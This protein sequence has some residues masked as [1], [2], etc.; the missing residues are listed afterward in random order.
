M[1][2]IKEYKGILIIVLVVIL[3]AFYWYEYRPTM[4]IKKC[5]DISNDGS[6]SLENLANKYIP[7]INQTTKD[8]MFRNCL[9]K[10]GIN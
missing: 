10:N 3:G 8:T 7:G 6:S 4:I 2:K 5:Y 1:E 9:K